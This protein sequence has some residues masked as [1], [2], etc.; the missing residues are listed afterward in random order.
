MD[1]ATVADDGGG[2][3][4]IDPQKTGELSV[5]PDGIVSQGTERIGKVGVF[6]FANLGALEKKGSNLYQNVSNQQPTSATDAKVRQ[7]MLEGSNV[8]S[9]VEITRMIEVSRAY[10][11]TT[12]MMASESDL[13][14]NSIARL[15]RVN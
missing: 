12:Q 4:T 7:G 15:G 11:Q 3:I 10:E 5:S 13:S 14:R 1:G 8:N 6:A 9:I 2:E